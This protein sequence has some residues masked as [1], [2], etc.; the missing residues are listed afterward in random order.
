MAAVSWKSAVSGNWT[1]AAD[2]STGKVPGAADDAT[3][4][5]AGFYTVSLTSS[6]TVSSLTIS[7]PGATLAV[8]AKD[9]LTA[10]SLINTGTIDL[11]GGILNITGSGGG[12]G[13]GGDVVVAVKSPQAPAAASS[14]AT[15][16][17]TLV[18]AQKASATTSAGLVNNGMIDVA[19]NVLGTGD[20]GGSAMTIGGTLTNNGDLDIGNSG[21]TVAT[22]VTATGL[23]N[24]ALGTINLIGD[25]AR[26]TLDITGTGGA[27]PAT[28]TGA[29]FLQGDALLEFASGHIAT[30]ATNTV[31]SLD[32]AKSFV[33]LSSAPTSNSA[34][35]LLHLNDGVINL[36]DHASI[37]VTSTTA[38]QNFGS[39]FVDLYGDGGSSLKLA[40]SLNN[41]IN[42]DIEIGSDSIT[43]AATLTAAGLTD[44]GTVYLTGAAGRATLDITGAAFATVTNTLDLFGNALLEFGSGSITAIAESGAL[45]LDGPWA[46]IALSGDTSSSGALAGLAGNAGTFTLAD[47]ASVATS[48]GLANSGTTSIDRFFNSSFSN[49]GGGSSLSIGGTLNNSDRLEIGNENITA[50]TTVTA[51]GL[52]NTG[53]I[54]LEGSA[55]TQAT[56]NIAAVAPTALTAGEYEL[57]GDALLE[58]ASGSIGAIDAGVVLSLDGTK[59]RVASG[60]ALGSNTA[61][62]GLTSNAGSFTLADGAKVTTAGGLTNTDFVAID[63]SSAGGSSLTVGG[64]LSNVDFL[65]IGNAEITAAVTVTAAGLAN[66]GTIE[67]NGGTATQATLK[68]TGTAPTALTSGSSSSAAMRCGITAPAAPSPRSISV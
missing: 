18:L 67:L 42:G 9:S 54:S 11:T 4:G 62:T 21:L 56:L 30:V 2:W 10:G 25:T 44:T 53:S 61:L 46:R 60:S 22:T 45:V 37:G 39:I 20:A 40:G 7:D 33:A 68:I 26:A 49:D 29:V 47:G 28:L 15:N 34:L 51:A 64:T 66:T 13:G 36:Q 58:Y 35:T 52:S 27:A 32:G 50:A 12:G 65:E 41:T 59:S 16:D 57:S 23:S 1:T 48:V 14:D 19:A 8:A 5:V 6:V 3:I 31:L 63:K 55:G 24:T 38:F 17:G 43:A